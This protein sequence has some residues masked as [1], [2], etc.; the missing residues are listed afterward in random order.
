PLSALERARAGPSQSSSPMR[1]LIVLPF[2][3]L[4]PDP[5]V[6]FLSASLPDAISSTLSSI[7]S[8]QARAS[9]TAAKYAAE[10]PDLRAIASE[11]GVDT[12]LTGSVL[13]AGDEL[14]V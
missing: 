9:L 2:R 13:R 8:F 10:A 3:V 5:E 6:D 7:G 14:Q 4:R 12:V 11:A 1:R